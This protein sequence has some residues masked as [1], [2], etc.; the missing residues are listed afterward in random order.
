[1]HRHDRLPGVDQNFL[2][3]PVWEPVRQHS[4][5]VRQGTVPAGGV[6]LIVTVG[7]KVTSSSAAIIAAAVI[8]I[9]G[10]IVALITVFIV[11][12]R[13]ACLSVC[14]TVRQPSQQA[15]LFSKYVA[16][17]S[18]TLSST[19]YAPALSVCLSDSLSRHFKCVQ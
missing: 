13:Y 1:M 9:C 7:D 4:R 3:I 11:R 12:T 15:F 8:G 19:L 17:L 10:V 16:P 2:R 5:S 14:L 18:S 6:Q